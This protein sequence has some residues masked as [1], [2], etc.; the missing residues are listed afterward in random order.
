MFADLHLHSVYSDGTDTPDELITLALKN[1]ISV[2]SITDHDSIIGYKNVSNINNLAI[3][4]ILGIEISTIFEH[5]YL[6]IRV[7]YRH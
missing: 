4:I 6:H 2:I 5:A 3:K 1:K 7:L